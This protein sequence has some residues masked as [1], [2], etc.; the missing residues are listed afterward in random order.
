MNQWS[1]QVDL[2]SHVSGDMQA[3]WSLTLGLASKWGQFS[4]VAW[5]MTCRVR[6]CTLLSTVQKHTQVNRSA[7]K[8]AS[9]LSMRSSAIP[10]IFSKTLC[11]FS[12]IVRETQL[13]YMCCLTPDFKTAQTRYMQM[14]YQ[15]MV[16]WYPTWCIHASVARAWNQLCSTAVCRLYLSKYK[17]SWPALAYSI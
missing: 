15:S 6:S 7:K 16:L 10:N 3:F 11:Y 14:G 2:A 9:K 8:D 1:L 4:Q 13:I 5:V 12:L 17:V